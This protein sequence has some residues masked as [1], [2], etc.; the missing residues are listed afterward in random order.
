MIILACQ[1]KLIKMRAKLANLNDCAVPFLSSP[2]HAC[3]Y[4]TT[5]NTNLYNATN[6]N[7]YN[8]TNTN[9]YNDYKH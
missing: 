7:L 8:A 3:S 1:L 2:T 9:L 5:T 4:I 6:T